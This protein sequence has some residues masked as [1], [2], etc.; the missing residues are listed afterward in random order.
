MSNENEG[1]I[2]SYVAGEALEAYRRVRLNSSG[3]VV[4]ADANE[5]HIGTTTDAQP[6]SGA[7][8]AVKMKN[9]PGTRK[10]VAAG[11][12]TS[13]AKVYGAADGKVNDAEAGLG[14][15]VGTALEAADSGS[16]FEVDPVAP[17]AALAYSNVADSAQV[18]N[19]TTVT[20]F[21]KSHTIPASELQVGDVIEVIARAFVEDNNST[22]TLEIKLLA[23]TEEI[24]TTGAVD[25][26]DNDIAYIHAF[27]TVRALGA[28]GA[29][30]A[31]GV[32]ANGVP[33]TVTAKPFRKAQATEDIAAG[34][35]IT[36]T[37]GWS[38][39]HADNEVE[40]EDL[41]V[42]HHRKAA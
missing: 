23:N 29:L 39:A 42:I 26:A 32:V 16:V 11:A 10:M 14:P 12:I 13:G 25:S 36:V 15:C 19:T 30:S 35:A 1:G 7:M 28:S 20:A 8:V 6:T 40:L 31:S 18:E 38:V 37:A 17:A 3:Q 22:D 27:I 33:G 5:H 9:Y 2:R 24:V 4:Y 21:D 34:I 41:I